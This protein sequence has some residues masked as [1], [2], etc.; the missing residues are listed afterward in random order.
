VFLR[1]GD[2][3]PGG[4]EIHLASPTGDRLLVTTRSSIWSPEL[5]PDST[6]IAYSDAGL[7]YLLDVA[8]SGAPEFVTFGTEVAW[9]DDGTLMVHDG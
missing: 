6:R 1:P 4:T 5:S 9:L 7:V 8:A 2:D 3:R